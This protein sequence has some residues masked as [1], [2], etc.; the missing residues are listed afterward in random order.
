MH[1]KKVCT[2]AKFLEKKKSFFRKFFF[3]TGL[4][5]ERFLASRSRFFEKVN[6][7]IVIIRNVPG[8]SP[9]MYRV[10]VLCGAEVRVSILTNATCGDF[11]LN[12]RPDRLEEEDEGDDVEEVQGFNIRSM[13]APD[14]AP[15]VGAVKYIHNP[16]KLNDTSAGPKDLAGV[17]I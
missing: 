16:W 10:I 15:S 9:V 7:V 17:D 14:T 4:I 1:K 11:P 6:V 5:F 12:G 3:A 8:Y 2:Y 13:K